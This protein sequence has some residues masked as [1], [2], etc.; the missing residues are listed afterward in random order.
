MDKN[1]TNRALPSGGGGVSSPLLTWQARWVTAEQCRFVFGFV[2]GR[3]GGVGGRAVVL[4]LAERE[5]GFQ[6][7]IS[8]AHKPSLRTYWVQR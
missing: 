7:K 3:G 4:S 2:G 5:E 1:S 6:I 8:T